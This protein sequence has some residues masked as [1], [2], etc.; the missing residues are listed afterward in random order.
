MKVSNSVIDADLAYEVR[1]VKSNFAT[2]EQAAR[3]CGVDPADLRA[4]LAT[5]APQDS[6][7]QKKLFES[8]DR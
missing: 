2:V 6:F 3:T 1:M 4:R 5:M 7:Q 8:F